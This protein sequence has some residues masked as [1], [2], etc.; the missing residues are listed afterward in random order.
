[1]SGEAVLVN[2]GFE[3]VRALLAD[4]GHPHAPLW[5]DRPVRTCAEAAQALGVAEGQ[6]AKSLVFR[7]V[8]D[9]GAVL[10]I[11]SGDRRVDEAKVA[12]L[13]GRADGELRRAE[14]AFVK[15]TTGFAIGGV[16]PIGHAQ[17]MMVVIDQDL[18]RF[19]EVWAAAGHPNGVFKASPAQL[20]SLTGAPFADLVVA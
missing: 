10:V 18:M 1:V 2:T 11:A 14:A 3:R 13:C 6:I 20:S 12:A 15:A 17:A 4:R 9:D 16:A 7:R 5:L 8:A 19:G